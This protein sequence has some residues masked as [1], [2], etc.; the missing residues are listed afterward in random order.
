MPLIRL[1]S[2]VLLALA[3]AVAHAEIYKC[4]GKGGM[5]LYQN[6]PCEFDSL[7][8]M[9]SSPMPRAAPGSALHAS[10]GAPRNNA[11]TVR[12]PPATGAAPRVGMS[13][14]DIRTR[15][16]QPLETSKEEHAE[17]DIEIW[18]YAG[19][20]SVHFDRKGRVAAAHW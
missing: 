11:S 20:R 3:P 5:P 12:E 17:E 2:L 14:R 6:F 19:S 1:L 15:W 7:G 13:R 4:A 9:P 8:A 16:G 18:T 10:N